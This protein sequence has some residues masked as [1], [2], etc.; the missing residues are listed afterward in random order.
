MVDRFAGREIQ[1]QPL[2]AVGFEML[3]T[4]QENS[5][6]W[7]FDLVKNVI[8]LRTRVYD[9]HCIKIQRIVFWYSVN[10]PRY[11]RF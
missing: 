5:Q 2:G 1:E 7:K 8:A 9:L 10:I 11:I 6:G 3:R 4:L